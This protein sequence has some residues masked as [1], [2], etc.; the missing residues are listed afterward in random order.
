MFLIC[1]NCNYIWACG[2]VA[3]EGGNA[4]NNLL[5]TT[6][7][8]EAGEP[9]EAAARHA[10]EPVPLH[11]REHGAPERVPPRCAVPL[12]E[13]GQLRGDAP[14][15]HQGGARGHQQEHQEDPTVQA[16][17]PGRPQGCEP[18]AGG[19]RGRLL[20]LGGGG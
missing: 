2:Q 16:A 9:P 20:G 6:P 10:A 19:Q 18:A 1:S 14:L 5:L 8:E 17:Q 12:Q 13:G 4:G 15:R 11:Q 7:M 3:T